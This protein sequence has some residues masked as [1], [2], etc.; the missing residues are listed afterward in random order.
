MSDQQY[1][2]EQKS[3]IQQFIRDYINENINELKSEDK[4]SDNSFVFLENETL[5][6]IITYMLTDLDSHR[7][8]DNK[9]DKVVS[10]DKEEISAHLDSLMEDN[11]QKFEEVIHMLKEEN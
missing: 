11:K 2:Q 5:Q 8:D 1:N 9:K 3:L 4:S 10:S 6:T 7:K